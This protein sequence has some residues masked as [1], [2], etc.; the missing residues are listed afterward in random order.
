MD[1]EAV[2]AEQDTQ[3]FVMLP[4]S[5]EQIRDYLHMHLPSTEALRAAAVIDDTYNLKQLAERPILLRFIRE[6]IFQLEQEKLAGRTINITRLYDILI[7]QTLARD[8]PKHVVPVDEKK[9]LLRA[10]ALSMHKDALPNLSH[11]ALGNWFV[12]TASSLPRLAPALASTDGLRHS[13][14]FLQD[15]RNAS[16]LIRPGDNVFQFA[17]TSIREYFLADAL[18]HA[19]CEGF[20]GQSVTSLC[21]LSKHLRSC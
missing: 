16:L 8:N 20:G 13:E 9:A 2:S 5:P 15:L 14:V 12:R 1:R 17:H 19:I 6:I 11:A 3:T 10:L 21:L 18:Y 7:D 4:F